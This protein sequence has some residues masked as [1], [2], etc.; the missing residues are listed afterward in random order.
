VGMNITK[1]ILPPSNV[2]RKAIPVDA[3]AVD[4]FV[5]SFRECP[6]EEMD[7]DFRPAAYGPED[8][9]FTKDTAAQA[10]GRRY[11]KAVMEKLGVTVRVRVDDNGVGEQLDENGKVIKPSADSVDADGN[12]VQGTR[13]LW[14]LY[15]PLSVGMELAPVEDTAGQEEA[16][17]SD[18]E[19]S[20]DE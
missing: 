13:Y 12:K 2:G 18:T 8:H 10:E 17:E 15:V 16:S 11:S 19:A 7:E 14:R 1:T 4:F 3:E 9:L 6:I 5:K 20:D